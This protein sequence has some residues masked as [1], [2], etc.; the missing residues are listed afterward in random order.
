MGTNLATYL[1]IKRSYC[2][3]LR[4]LNLPS[5]QYG[6]QRG[7]LIYLHQLLKGIYNIHNQFFIPSNLTTTIK[8]FTTTGHTK[9][10][11]KHHTSSYVRSNFYSNKVINNWNSLPQFIVDYSFYNEFK[12]LLD[13]HYSD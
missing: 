6:R 11:F 3:R 12:M 5:L 4:Y 10:L 13:S 2:D 8:R 7:D 1:I 9:K